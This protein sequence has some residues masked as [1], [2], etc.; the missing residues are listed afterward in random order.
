MGL[1]PLGQ[2]AVALT[3]T[4]A[5][6]LVHHHEAESRELD[7]VL[8][9]GMGTHQQLQLAMAQT[10]LFPNMVVQMVAIGEESGSLDAMLGKVADF[11]EQEVDDAVDGLSSLLE[12]LI[13]AILGILVIVFVTP[14]PPSQGFHRD[15]QLSIQDV[16]RIIGDVELLKLVDSG[17]YPRRD[18]SHNFPGC[19]RYGLCGR[20]SG[21]WCGCCRSCGW[22]RWLRLGHRFRNCQR[23]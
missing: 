11:Y 21:G 1:E 19:F 10:G 15:A 4:E 14:K 12:P 2:Q 20:F 9:Q 23:N 16:G 22:F 3:D 8:Q 18:I 5:V 13:M 17:C 7:R 6:L